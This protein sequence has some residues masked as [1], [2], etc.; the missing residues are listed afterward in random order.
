MVNKW[1]CYV[2]NGHRA[3]TTIDHIVVA[4][5]RIS[6]SVFVVHVICRWYKNCY[7]LEAVV[8]SIPPLYTGL[9]CKFS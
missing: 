5:H 2:R 3:R 6:H 9:G 7:I 8:K 1:K 4:M